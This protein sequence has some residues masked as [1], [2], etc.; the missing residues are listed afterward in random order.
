MKIRQ[1]TDLLDAAR[2]AKCRWTL[3]VAAPHEESVLQAVAEAC[4]QGFARAVLFGSRSQIDQA[5]RDAGVILPADLIT[6]VETGDDTAMARESTRCVLTGGADVLVKG[7]LS[8]SLL[9]RTVLQ[10]DPGPRGSKFMSHVG[11][12]NDPVSGRLMLLTDAGINIAPNVQRKFQI[13]QHAVRVAHALGIAEPKVAMLAAVEKLNYPAMP[14]T[15]DAALVARIAA[16][17]AIPN[18]IVE[19]PFALDNVVSPASAGKKNVAG[20][21]AG[22]ADILCGPDIETSNA[23]YKALQTFCGVTFASVVVGASRPV[24]VPSRVDSMQT[25]LMSIA[26]AC[27]LS[28][29]PSA[30]TAGPRRL[31]DLGLGSVQGLVPTASDPGNPPPG[32]GVAC[33]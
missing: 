17:G 32:E 30:E 22:C 7:L 18:A 3:S 14:A 10:Q 1:V 27:L 24:A 8:T 6:I 33:N 25:K 19:G 29:K 12:F 13:V 11:V 9:M 23:L 26:L 21:V 28:G 15:L 31:S 4:R 20:R 5:A 2:D 16:S